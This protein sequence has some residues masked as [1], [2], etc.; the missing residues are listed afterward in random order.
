MKQLRIVAVFLM[1]VSLASLSKVMAQP[2]FEVPLT[3]NDG[4]TPA[5]TAYFGV[6]TGADVCVNTADVFN[7]HAETFLPPAP[8][9]GVFDARWISPRTGPSGP[10]CYD[11]G[12]PNDFRPFVSGAQKDTFRVKAQLTT[13]TVT[14]TVSW[15]AGLSARFLA[16][17]TLRYFDQ[18]LGANVNVD[19]LTT[20]S[21]NVT[22]AGDPVTITI[23]SNGL[24][25]PIVAPV[26]GVA[27]SV[28]PFGS[29]GTSS[30]KV[31]SV[32]VSNTGLAALN[33]TATGSNNAAFTVL[34][35][36]P[37][38][39]PPAGSMMFYITFAPSS[40]GPQAGTISFT[41][42]AAGSPGTVAVSGTGVLAPAAFEFGLTVNDGVTPAGT[43]YFGLYPLANNCIAVTDIFNTHAE[44]FLPP[45]PPGGVFDSRF[46]SPR[47]GPSGPVCYDQGS[48]HDFRPFLA[49]G[50][51]DTFRLKAQL[52]TG[53]V[54]NTI[55]WPNNMSTQFAVA[56]LRYF[57][58]VL[59]ANVDVNMLTTFS[60]NVTDAGDP[61]TVTIYTTA[62]TPGPAE[63]AVTPSSLAFGNV[64]ICPTAKTDSVTVSNP[65]GAPLNI[66]AISAP[67]QYS[68][69]PSAPQ[70]IS[71][72]GSMKFYVTFTA[73]TLGAH[74]GN[75][76]FT[77]NA[78]TL[79]SPTNVSVTGAGIVCPPPPPCFTSTPNPLNF[80]AV[81]DS[82]SKLDSIVITNGDAAPMVITG[83]TPSDPAYSVTP[84]SGTI[85]PSGGTLKFY[86]TFAPLDPVPPVTH[87]GT[88]S[89]A[90]TGPSCSPGIVNVTGFSYVPG[91][92][93]YTTVPP[94][95]LVQWAG[96][97]YQRPAVRNP[98]VPQFPNWANL[99]LEVV[100]QG[101][102]RPG[103]TESDTLGGMRL[104]ISHLI[105]RGA[106]NNFYP[107]SMRGDTA[108]ARLSR[109]VPRVLPRVSFGYGSSQIQISLLNRLG[110]T[111]YRHD[112]NNRGFDS[113]RNPGDLHRHP[114]RGQQSGLY[115]R[116]IKN[117]L[118]GELV[119]LKFNIASS[120]LGKTPAGF[121]DALINMS[122][123]PLNGLS[124]VAAS[125]KID[126][127]MTDWTSVPQ[128]FL[129][130]CYNALRLIN[131]ACVGPLDTLNSLVFPPDTG[132]FYKDKNLIVVGVA[133]LPSYL[134][135]T[136]ARPT[137]MVP[138]NL[139][140][141]ATELSDPDFS[142]PEGIEEV[143]V[144]LKLYQ[145]Y[146]NP[147]N[148]TTT[149]NFHLTAAAQ[150]NLTVYNVLGQEVATIL[151]NEEL[152]D[153]L[154]SLSFD[155]GRLSSGVYF[156]IVTGQDLESGAAIPRSVGKMLLLK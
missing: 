18:V 95:S 79:P 20:T 98:R 156:Y 4:V 140:T 70:T 131:R 25:I 108:W 63:F 136:L 149:I 28:L 64:T 88:L 36:A 152:P 114:L 26:F 72:G 32:V 96:S 100:Y 110:T 146:P 41:H 60:A 16:P 15:P 87:N 139:G 117:Q 84:T 65:G 138:L 82:T 17:L 75:V 30:T 132:S 45:P 2:A 112:A 150:V 13:G 103:A 52:T 49:P 107:R 90:F 19:M 77:H 80:G 27:P 23:Y 6:Y 35:A 126:S 78:A 104:G 86:V 135:S 94:E 99:L 81:V 50:Q 38:N 121:G 37:Q 53:T 24:V 128:S 118:F 66:T 89:F 133:P 73:A 11:Q 143:P 123:N 134:I 120:Q 102:F 3:V 61:V 141:E 31:D 33:I 119:A 40:A 55:S 5:A 51:L 76:S 144:A 142:N 56:R 109:W 59:G 115:P 145:N 54:T 85:P 106:L 113:T 154:Q 101:G 151:N 116:F 39:I 69:S 7:A 124:L 125:R 74:N 155:A 34:P 137:T 93:A 71:S 130:S 42:N 8:P 68:V 46:I 22:D 97:Y 67:A 44:T 43:G 62:T 10:V 105:Q 58:Q 129:D 91:A 153:G 14:T 147:F 148:P 57:D 111:F 29:V 47:T 83:V 92:S 9:G 48:P 1:L 122:G 21:A 127:V 12:S